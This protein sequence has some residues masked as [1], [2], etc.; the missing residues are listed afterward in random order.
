MRSRVQTCGLDLGSIGCSVRVRTYVRVCV[1]TPLWGHP[2]DNAKRISRNTV[3]EDELLDEFLVVVMACNAG[4]DDGILT[5]RHNPLLPGIGTGRTLRFQGFRTTALIKDTWVALGGQAH[6][7]GT[8]SLRGGGYSQMI[9]D[10]GP[11][12]SSAR[13]RGGWTRKSVIPQ[14]CYLDF[15]VAQ[16]GPSGSLRTDSRIITVARNLDIAEG[17]RR[18]PLRPLRREEGA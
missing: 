14:T 12:D 11:D 2:A 9:E 1:R 4:L 7:V 17:R 15:V 8:H 3:Q 10:R 18:P 16:S 6:K 5:R 13:A